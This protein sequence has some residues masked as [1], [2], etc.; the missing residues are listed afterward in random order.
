MKFLIDADIPKSIFHLLKKIGHDVTDVRNSKFPGMSDDEVYNLAIK[1]QR[2]IITRDL[3]FSNI[4]H[5]PPGEHCGIIILRVQMLS[6]EKMALL[7]KDML[8]SI[9]EEEVKGSLIIIQKDR[10]RIRRNAK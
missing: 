4:L 1:E 7:V 9:T 2:I 6:I 3:D 10:Y 5:Y 8:N